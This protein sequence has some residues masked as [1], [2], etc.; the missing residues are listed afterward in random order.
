[1]YIIPLNK[2]M[3]KNMKTDKIKNMKTEI[4]KDNDKNKNKDNTSITRKEDI[5]DFT[6]FYNKYKAYLPDNILPSKNFLT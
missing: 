3:K 5:F 2:N 1:M 6:L 4:I